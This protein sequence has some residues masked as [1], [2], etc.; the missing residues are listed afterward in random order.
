MFGAIDPINI[1]DEDEDD[2][3]EVVVELTPTYPGITNQE[4]INL[5]FK[6][7]SEI[8]YWPWIVDAQLEDMAFPRENRTKPYTGP[9]I[10]D[11]PNLEDNEKEALLAQLKGEPQ[12]PADQPTYP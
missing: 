10:E 7:S 11:L 6:A 8:L 1:T 12:E 9:K 2:L 5:F 3:D 4:M